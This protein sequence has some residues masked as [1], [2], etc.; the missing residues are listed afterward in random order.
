MKLI[1]EYFWDNYNLFQ[2]KTVNLNTELDTLDNILDVP[3]VKFESKTY[4][5]VLINENTI[6]I[7]NDYKT[8]FVYCK[9]NETSNENNEKKNYKEKLILYKKYNNIYLLP[10]IL[11]KINI[12][13]IK[14][15][16]PLDNYHINN[17]FE[18]NF[19][20]IN[21]KEEEYKMIKYILLNLLNENGFDEVEIINEEENLKNYSLM[22]KKINELNYIR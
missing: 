18:V 9:L 3:E 7:N 13:C 14:Y 20:I 5:P 4:K 15:K 19:E 10:T 16:L 2:S 6:S 22:M 17:N 21:A 11:K 8:Y 1:V 12:H